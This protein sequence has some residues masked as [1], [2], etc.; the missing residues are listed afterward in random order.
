MSVRVT[1]RLAGVTAGIKDNAITGPG[2]ALTDR[3]LVS[4]RRYLGKQ[5]VLRACEAREVRIVRFG[6]DEHMNR[7]LRIDVAKCEGAF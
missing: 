1:H 5:P 2:N 7:S 6:N 4:L 3:N